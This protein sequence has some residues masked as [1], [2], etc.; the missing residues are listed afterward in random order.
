[1]NALESHCLSA[2]VD[3][4]GSWLWHLRFGH[5]NFKSLSLLN[6]KGMVSGMTPIKLPS[7]VCESCLVSKQ[8]RNSFGSYTLERSTAVLDVIYSDVCGPIDTVSLGGNKYFVSFID[9]FSRKIWVYLLK[10][11]SEVFSVF[12]VFKSMAEKQSGKYIKVLRTDGGGEFCSHEM[13]NFCTENG[14]LHEIV[15]PYT[16]QHNG[17]AERRNRT[18]LNMVRSM[19]KGKNMSHTFWGEAVMTAA[20]VLNLCP[21]KKLGSKVPEEI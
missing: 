16:P 1:M 13:E 6:S 19:L 3:K 9:E 21:T 17:I 14:I 11:K 20:Y 12:K 2:E 4:D 18:I 8:S 10:A 5:L 15:A 7:K